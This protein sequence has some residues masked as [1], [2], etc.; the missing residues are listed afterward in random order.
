MN[1]EDYL[2]AKELYEKEHW[3]KHI[4]KRC[5]MLKYIWDKERNLFWEAFEKV[6]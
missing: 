3:H 4:Y 6:K 1:P 5:D 2:L